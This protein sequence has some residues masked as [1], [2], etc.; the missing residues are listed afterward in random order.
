VFGGRAP[1][2]PDIAKVEFDP[3]RAAASLLLARHPALQRRHSLRRSRLFRKPA[4]LL[5][6]RHSPGARVIDLAGDA[7][8]IGQ[9]Q[10]RCGNAPAGTR[11][12]VE[13][14]AQ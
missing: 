14:W 9:V 6:R 13:L 10:L 5:D 4:R 2:S 11:A 3:R 12:Q 1:S 8:I 7:R